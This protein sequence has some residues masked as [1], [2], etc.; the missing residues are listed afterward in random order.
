M[1]K[2]IF[3][4]TFD[5]FTKGH[6]DIVRKAS[7]IFDEVIVVL[8]FN[9]AKTRRYH[10][11]LMSNAV[12]EAIKAEGI[13]NVIVGSWDNI[14]VEL[15]NQWHIIYFIKG[16]RD[17]E[18]YLYEEKMAKVNKALYPPIEYVYLRA[19]ND[20]ISSSMVKELFDHGVD[21]TPYVPE[22]VL[23]FMKEEAELKNGNNENSS[24]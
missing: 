2:A 8:A 4:G 21:L 11:D 23:N 10:P 18:D 12:D 20:I 17:V 9:P 15:L 7:K 24:R 19:D 16:L 1:K 6:L 14:I 5:P 3:A 13:T 22:A